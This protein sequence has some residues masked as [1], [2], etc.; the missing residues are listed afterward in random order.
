[1]QEGIRV[2]NVYSES[3]GDSCMRG[4]MVVRDV[5]VLCTV[6][7][8]LSV[9]GPEAGKMKCCCCFSLWN[10]TEHSVPGEND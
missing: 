6:R 7:Q 1:M 2:F 3:D 9:Q 5:Q 10:C 4:A 8:E